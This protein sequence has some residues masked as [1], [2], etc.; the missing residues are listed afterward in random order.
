MAKYVDMDT[1]SPSVPPSADRNSPGVM[2][3]RIRNRF[4]AERSYA[5]FCSSA[6]RFVC[7][8]QLGCATGTDESRLQL[9]RLIRACQAN[10]GASA[11]R[12]RARPLDTRPL[13]VTPQRPK[14][15]Q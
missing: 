12:L 8:R 15:R 6:W 11:R 5:G 2:A 14:K 4:V 1:M 7:D 9:E 10:Y 3:K 13:I